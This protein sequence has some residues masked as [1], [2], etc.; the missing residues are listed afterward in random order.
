MS[1]TPGLSTGRNHWELLRCSNPECEHEAQPRR[2]GERKLTLP[3]QVCRSDMFVLPMAVV[4]EVEG[5]FDL[6]DMDRALEAAIEQGR[7]NAQK[8]GSP[9]VMAHFSGLV[10]GYKTAREMLAAT[11]AVDQDG[12]SSTAV[13]GPTLGAPRTSRTAGRPDEQLE[14]KEEISSSGVVADHDPE[15]CPYCLSPEGPWPRPERSGVAR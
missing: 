1:A 5:G 13:G 11:G 15:A 10:Q 4:A 12:P 9:D 14:H 6:G 3:C 7:V 2:A 8:R